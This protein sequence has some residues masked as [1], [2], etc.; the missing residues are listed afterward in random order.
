MIKKKMTVFLNSFLMSMGLVCLSA[1]ASSVQWSVQQLSR[2]ITTGSPR[3]NQSL[4][5]PLEVLDAAQPLTI[6]RVQVSYRHGGRAVLKSR[7]C[8][9]GNGPCVDMNGAY[10]STRA[11]AGQDARRGFVLQHEVWTWAGST[12]PVQVQADIQVWYERA[13]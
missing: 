8:L 5:P 7:L 1:Q 4:M 6:S 2:P 10:L 12:V 3:T 11:F 9:N 13:Q